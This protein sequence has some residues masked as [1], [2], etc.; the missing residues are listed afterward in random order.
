MCYEAGVGSVDEGRP[1]PQS[2]GQG[3]GVDWQLSLSRCL[4]WGGR[5]GDQGS[6][7]RE[8]DSTCAGRTGCGG[9]LPRN[10][11]LSEPCRPVYTRAE[12]AS[13][14]KCGHESLVK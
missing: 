12:A 4:Q 3:P 8:L 9:D 5:E 13:W 7:F 1:P 10:G 6:S 11:L 2:P 14:H